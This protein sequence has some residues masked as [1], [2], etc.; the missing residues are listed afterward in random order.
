[1]EIPFVRED[2][3]SRVQYLHIPAD[4]DGSVESINKLMKEQYHFQELDTT[5]QVWDRLRL[6]KLESMFSVVE[7]PDF[8]QLQSKLDT[9]DKE[10]ENANAWG[11]KIYDNSME[12]TAEMETEMKRLQSLMMQKPFMDCYLY[13]FWV[14]KE[15]DPIKFKA[16]FQKLY[17]QKQLDFRTLADGLDNYRKFLK[18]TNK[19]TRAK[20]VKTLAGFLHNLVNLTP[21]G[22][23]AIKKLFNGN[24]QNEL[25]SFIAAFEHVCSQLK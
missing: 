22:I 23:D 16:D 14:M 24:E 12:Y 10:F 25:L 13:A 7:K 6:L 1:M 20:T 8:K 19:T 11:K 21:A 5:Y 18:K 9:L 2:I 15:R 3:P 4:C 17:L